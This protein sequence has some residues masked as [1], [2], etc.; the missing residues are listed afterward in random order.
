MKPSA[1]HSGFAFGAP[2]ITNANRSLNTCW[3]V[4]VVVSNPRSSTS[5]KRSNN[6]VMSRSSANLSNQVSSY[7]IPSRNSINSLRLRGISIEASSFKALRAPS[8]NRFQPL[9]ETI[10]GTKRSIKRATLMFP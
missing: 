10:D 1:F 7:D 6:F 8:Q 9:S 3:A 4:S 2:P 5:L